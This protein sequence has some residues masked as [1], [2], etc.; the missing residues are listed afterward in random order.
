[1]Q[2]MKSAK[3]WSLNPTF[4]K[5]RKETRWIKSLVLRIFNE[6]N[7]R[8]S[9]PLIYSIDHCRRWLHLG[10]LLMLFWIRLKNLWHLPTITQLIFCSWS[11][12]VPALIKMY[13]ALLRRKTFIKEYLWIR[14]PCHL[15]KKSW[16]WLTS[17]TKLRRSWRYKLKPERTP[18]R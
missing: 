15:I 3:S 6:A 4:W 18:L 14:R 10:R 7:G 13:Y 5:I 2:K 17:L 12:N 1:M 8:N 16:S 11:L 9:T